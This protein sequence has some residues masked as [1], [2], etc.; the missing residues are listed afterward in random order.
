MIELGLPVQIVATEHT[1]PGF[2]EA[3]V[4]YF[5]NQRK[6]DRAESKQ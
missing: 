2:V 4:R 5:I 1:G 6:A 3:I